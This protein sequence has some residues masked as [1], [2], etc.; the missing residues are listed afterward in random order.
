V[1]TVDVAVLAFG[2]T[3]HA[4]N[5]ARTQVQPATSCLIISE[6]RYPSGR[7][8]KSLSDSRR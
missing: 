3:V 2:G 4:S 8:I 1:G 5:Y 6:S 7:V